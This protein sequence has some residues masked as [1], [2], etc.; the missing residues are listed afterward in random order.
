MKV[1]CIDNKIGNSRHLELG[2][3]YDASEVNLFG[4]ARQG[5][6]IIKLDPWFPSHVRGD[7]AYVWVSEDCLMTID[8]WRELQ[9]D[10]IL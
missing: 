4:K 2:K 8:K 10:K 7:D 3:F 9:L 1:V 5:Y 6:L